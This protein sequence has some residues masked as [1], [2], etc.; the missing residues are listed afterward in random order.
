MKITP[1]GRF[2][3]RGVLSTPRLWFRLAR[4]PGYRGPLHLS[5]EVEGR[6][7]VYAYIRKNACTSF[8][9]YLL[10][11]VPASAVLERKTKIH[12]LIGHF[13][14][15]YRRDF[16]DADRTVFVHRDPVDRA[17]SLYKNKFIQGREAT[18]IHGDYERVVGAPAREA[19]F[20]LFVLKYLPNAADPHTSTQ[21]SHLH[22]SIYTDA[23]PIEVLG[24]TMRD[25]L[26]PEVADKYFERP[27]NAS[28]SHAVESLG[29]A[30]VGAHE[31][32]SDLDRCGTYPSRESFVPTGGVL[33]L[34]LL[35]KYAEDRVFSRLPGSSKRSLWP[36]SGGTT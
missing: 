5:F 27:T 9:R 17:V 8:K 30:S 20:A 7:I 36:A 19:T 12:V 10:D 13:G 23:I 3:N 18:D 4:R 32:A 28:G 2:D 1:Q 33:H 16:R 25:V 6:R 26:S 15:E 35:D 21:R 29:A 11:Q 31:L 34:A 24:E 14:A 22:P